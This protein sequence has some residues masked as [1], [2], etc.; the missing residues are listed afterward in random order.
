MS[1]VMNLQKKANFWEVVNRAVCT[2]LI[3]E[4]LLRFLK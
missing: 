4:T 1:N 2:G 3:S